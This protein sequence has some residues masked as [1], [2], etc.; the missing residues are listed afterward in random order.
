MNQSANQ[1]R[2]SC[3]LIAEQAAAARRGGASRSW[4]LPHPDQFL[5]QLVGDLDRLRLQC[6]TANGK[7]TASV[8]LQGLLCG[9]CNRSIS[10]WLRNISYHEQHC[11]TKC[12]NVRG[13][14][15]PIAAPETF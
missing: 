4:P 6:D 5:Q 1:P 14:G 13:E 12:P 9:I 3:G 7:N 8:V 2:R 10:P 15:S 11:H